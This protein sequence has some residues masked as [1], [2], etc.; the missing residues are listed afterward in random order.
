MK[1]MKRPRETWY[2]PQ[3]YRWFEGPLKF[4]GL[5]LYLG[6]GIRFLQMPDG[7]WG[8]MGLGERL[9]VSKKKY[10]AGVS[11]TQ[12]KYEPARRARPSEAIWLERAFRHQMGLETGFVEA[13]IRD[14]ASGQDLYE[15]DQACPVQE[16]T[17]LPHE[18]QWVKYINPIA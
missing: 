2:S 15:I 11:P 1:R 8:A 17:W 3:T 6:I 14:Y 4:E 10:P 18:G 12:F 13:F 7:R 5:K 16:A 9:F